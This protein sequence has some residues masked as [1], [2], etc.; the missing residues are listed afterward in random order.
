LR[1]QLAVLKAEATLHAID[2]HGLEQVEGWV[3]V[4]ACSQMWAVLA[5][6]QLVSEFAAINLKMNTRLGLVQQQ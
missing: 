1:S 4:M 6:R 2:A 3:R 5:D